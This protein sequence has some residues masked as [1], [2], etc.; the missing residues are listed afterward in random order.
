MDLTENKVMLKYKNILHISPTDIRYDSRIL[1]EID[2]L[3]KIDDYK[4]KAFGINDNEG[5]NYIPS[6]N[7]DIYA[8]SLFSKKINFIPR[9]L[10]YFFNLIEAILRL[11]IPLIRFNPR[12]IHCHDTLFLPLALIGKLICKSK[13]IYDAHELESDKAGQTKMLSKYTLYIEKKVWKHIDLLISVSPS[14]LDWYKNNIGEKGNLLIVNSPLLNKREIEKNNQNYFRDKYNIPEGDKIFLYLGIISR[15][16]R[17]IKLCLDVFKKHDI[18]SHIVFMGY[19]D[20]SNDIKKIAL[21]Y[22]NIHY[23]S[24]VPHDMVVNISK[25]ADVGLCLLEPVSLSDYYCL[26]NKL[27]EYAFSG[28]YILASDFPDIKEIVQKYSLGECTNLNSDDVY[29]SIKM[30]EKRIIEN[31]NIDLYE[32]SWNYQAEKL[33]IGYKKILMK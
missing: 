11:T 4:I 27:F 17:G 20:Y 21:D 19:G 14:I 15:E 8:F 23:H 24:A 25:F 6:K 12:V 30:I 31:K 2:A 3:S 26:P 9:P 29:K 32:L 16:G 28:L 18:N 5:H 1:K 13:I 22:S 33:I 10:R 7:Y